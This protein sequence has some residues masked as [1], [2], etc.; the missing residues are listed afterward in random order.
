MDTHIFSK[1]TREIIEYFGLNA[2]EK[3]NYN[4][5]REVY[6]ELQKERNIST[7]EA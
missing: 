7:L 1:T 6:L 5:L 2:N 4:I 3:T